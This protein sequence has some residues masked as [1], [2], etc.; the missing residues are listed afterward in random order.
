MDYDII[1]VGGGPAGL[2]FA[3]ALAQT[4]LRIAVVE[5][6]QAAQL[7]EPPYDGREIALTHR[8][9]AILGDMGIWQL[10]PP[11]EVFPL[12]TAEVLNGN[13]RASVRFSP[14]LGESGSLGHIV[15][16]HLIRKAL[17]AAVA[18]QPNTRLLDGLK[19]I[20][21]AAGGEGAC[22]GLAEGAVLRARLLVAADSRFS[23]LRAHLGI[24][25]RLNP[26]ADR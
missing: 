4:R 10:V 26:L 11:K 2:S 8:S 19:V 5:S 23:S 16:N 13:S 25:A 14:M 20:R 15:S 6:Q 22:I 9:S 21:A 3:R 17:F 1:V 7:E 12:R 18:A 24:R